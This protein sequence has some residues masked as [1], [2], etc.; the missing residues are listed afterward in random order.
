MLSTR[1]LGS[2]MTAALAISLTLWGCSR[3]QASSSPSTAVPTIGI[4]V[5]TVHS[6]E[7]AQARPLR[8]LGTVAAQ[9]ALSVQVPRI[10]GQGSGLTL[11]RLIGNGNVVQT[12]DVL[13]EFDSTTQIK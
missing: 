7:P 11:V 13:A 1:Q 5:P 9:R 8:T 10:T 6:A 4:A 2:L 12:G 3:T